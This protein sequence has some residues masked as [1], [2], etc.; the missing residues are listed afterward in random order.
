M[1]KASGG[2]DDYRLDLCRSDLSAIA[3]R[4]ALTA[5]MLRFVWQLPAQFT[6]SAGCEPTA[7]LKEPFGAGNGA[8]VGAVSRQQRTTSP[9]GERSN[10]HTL[11]HVFAIQEAASTTVRLQ[12][13]DAA[14]QHLQVPHRLGQGVQPEVFHALR[15]MIH[16]TSE[17]WHPTRRQDNPAARGQAALAAEE[18]PNRDHQDARAR[19]D[20]GV[21][22]RRWRYQ[23]YPP[24]A[25]L[26]GLHKAGI[27]KETT[28]HST[29]RNSYQEGG[30]E[31]QARGPRS[32]PS[33]AGRRGTYT[34]RLERVRNR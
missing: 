25:G 2:S 6:L 21:G 30:Q 14:P 19:V 28:H 16:R 32:H 7:G 27:A 23:W 33:N 12:S 26:P 5:F 34:C 20:P 18:C 17:C 24:I 13:P 3:K 10:R 8:F 1:R 29:Y 22:G 9:P 11:H 15:R 4:R 31:Q